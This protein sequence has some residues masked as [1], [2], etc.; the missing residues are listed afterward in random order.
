MN[1]VL[2]FLDVS[3]LIREQKRV[4]DCINNSL[5]WFARLILKYFA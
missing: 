5:F 1:E 2:A 3:S 4:K